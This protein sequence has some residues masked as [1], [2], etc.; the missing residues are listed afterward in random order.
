MLAYIG[1]GVERDLAPR[2]LIVT[3][4]VRDRATSARCCRRNREATPN[5]SLHTTGW[6]FD[7]ARD[8]RRARR[9]RRSSSC[10]TA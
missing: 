2:P 9:R 4:T 3:S 5:F 6:S 7:I 8:Y 1:A 10:S